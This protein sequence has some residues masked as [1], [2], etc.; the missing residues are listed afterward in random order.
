MVAPMVPTRKPCGH[1]I[2]ELGLCDLIHSSMTLTDT[3]VI[4]LKSIKKLCLCGVGECLSVCLSV[5][6]LY[7][8]AHVSLSYSLS[9]P[10]L[11][12]C[13]NQGD[14]VRLSSALLGLL[15]EQW[16]RTHSLRCESYAAQPARFAT[17]EHPLVLV[18]CVNIFTVCWFSSTI[19][20]LAT[21]K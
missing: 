3:V 13:F 17:I 2:V 11:C 14:P 5:R 8:N 12:L 18:D 7:A 6:N 10:F 20:G 16:W 15:G 9:F 1:V 19:S 4:W 21:F